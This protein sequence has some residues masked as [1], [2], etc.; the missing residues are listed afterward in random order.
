MN[1]L[2][3]VQ[4]DRK[5]FAQFYSDNNYAVYAWTYID[6]HVNLCINF[7]EGFFGAATMVS[8][9]WS[10]YWI[11]V[12]NAFLCLYLYLTRVR[13]LCCVEFLFSFHAMSALS[14]KLVQS[15]LWCVRNN[16]SLANAI[17]YILSF[18]CFNLS[19]VCFFFSFIFLSS[20]LMLWYFSTRFLSVKLRIWHLKMLISDK[21]SDLLLHSYSRFTWNALQLC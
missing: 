13:A 21:I 7:L 15:N 3:D 8:F 4:T 19:F 10:A 20:K 9:W 14:L 18:I 6:T 5:Y 1:I 2:I 16:F 11:T 12:Y 17:A